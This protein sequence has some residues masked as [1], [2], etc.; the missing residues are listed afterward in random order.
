MRAF[1]LE[2]DASV[3]EQIAAHGERD[4]PNEACGIVFGPRGAT[5]VVRAAPITNVQDREHGRDPGAAPRTARDGFLLDPLEYAR[6]VE[7]AEREGLVERAV[8]HS[9]C[10]V[11]AYFSPEDR[12]MAVR[13]GHEILPGVVH[14]VVSVRGGRR[15][16]LAAFRW[17]AG[18]GT[19]D[20]VRLPLD[21][22][23][24]AVVPPDLV[25]R[26][27]EGGEAVRP[28]RPLGSALAPRRITPEE[29]ARFG[30]T[31]KLE[32]RVGDAAVLADLLRFELGLFSPLSG[33]MRSVEVRAIEQSGR[34]LSGTPWRTPV[35]LEL[36]IEP[37]AAVPAPGAFV[38]LVGPTG[39][40]RAVM[41]VEEVLQ[42]A[43]ST[44]RLGGPV[45]VYDSGHGLDAAESRAELLR[46]GAK[47]VLAASPALAPRLR[48][49]DVA[50][51]D[52]VLTP[53]PIE[54]VATWVELL[55]SGRDP[56]LDAVMAQNQGATHVWV[57]DAAIARQ[58]DDTLSIR[59]WR[60]PSRR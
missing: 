2:L 7:A 59:S 5:T 9:H 33:F 15:A 10:D 4:Y 31:E 8:Y 42:P 40:P 6:T 19:F 35:L 54:G 53:R 43:K 1:D 24:A 41:G 28:I 48:A 16:D 34:L 21:G 18:R 38:E 25:S 17:N 46:R 57:E 37:G 56:W 55:L 32:L 23:T 20:E 52:G 51:F 45:F 30:A 29:Q 47:R 49:K 3:L 50:D 58:I 14:L 22:A 27:M 26:A 36:P 13:D 60:P 39:E 11:G 12:A 44:L